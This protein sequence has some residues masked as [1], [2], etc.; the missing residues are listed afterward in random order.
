[1]KCG[2]C[3]GDHATVQETRECYE[4]NGHKVTKQSLEAG[5]KQEIRRNRF[6]GNCHRCGG[7][8][9]AEAGHIEKIDGGWK[10]LHDDV[11]PERK[12]K[13]D[14]SHVEIQNPAEF[15]AD[16]MAGYYA[17][18]SITGAQDFD[19]W[20]VDRPD[21]GKWSGH[22]FV[23]RV[24]G[25]RDDQIIPRDSKKHVKTKGAD[26][27]TQMRALAAIRKFGVAKA[28]ETF[29]LELKY[30]RICGIHLTDEV[31]RGLGIG[32]VCREKLCRMGQAYQR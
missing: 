2:N 15:F 13:Q 4:A 12:G 18:P 16:I 14:V 11:C 21:K 17:T 9:E 27:V 28:A 26:K 32:P 31:S 20:C 1:M 3:R 30:C 29:G 23:K 25:G 22:I 7:R 5:Q 19:F 24:I 6:A 10:V 8:V